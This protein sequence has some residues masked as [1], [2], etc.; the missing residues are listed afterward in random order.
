MNNVYLKMSKL[1]NLLEF[2]ILLLVAISPLVYHLWIGDKASI[3]FEITIA[4][5]VYYMTQL[6]TLL[7]ITLINGI[8]AIKLQTYFA[9]AVSIIH[10]PL[11]LFLGSNLHA[12]GVLASLILLN[13]TYAIFSSVQINRL[14]SQKASGIWTK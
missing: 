11:S 2:S 14:L 4:V 6:W 10:I 7:N 1:R 5:A 13:L 3:P 12:I 9:I 8:G